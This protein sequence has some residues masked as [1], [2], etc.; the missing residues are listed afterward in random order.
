VRGLTAILC[1][2]YTL[3]CEV[4]FSLRFEGGRELN[5]SSVNRNDLARAVYEVHGGLSQAESQR[6]VDGIFE[7]IR[8]R[9]LHGEKVLLSGF[10]CFRVRTRRERRGVNPQTGESI[11]VPGRKA[12]IF[13]PSRYLKSV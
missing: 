2:E 12:I 1:D 5:G 6:I 7:M 3:W 11:V 10:G 13:K 8:E 4:S 9:L